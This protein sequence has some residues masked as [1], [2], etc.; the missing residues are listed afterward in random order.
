MFPIVVLS[1]SGIVLLFLGFLKSRAVL[2]PATLACLVIATVAN[3]YDWNKTYVY[4]NDM[5]VINNLAM[6]FI[7]IVLLSAFMVVALSGSLLDD[8]DAQPAEYYA[9][10]LF[11]L[12]G[13]IMMIGY[14][15]LL[16]L[17][18][19]IE[20]L[21]VAM[22]ILTGSDKRNIRSNEAALKYFL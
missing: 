18:V 2:L 14:E 9:I 21:S 15:N 10:M 12:V 16:M 22:Y 19:G 20:I 3:F 1:I 13:A 17:F 7:G 4:F 5:L 11:S 6:V 8:E